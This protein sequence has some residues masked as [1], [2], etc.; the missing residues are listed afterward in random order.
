TGD[1]PLYEAVSA[2]RRYSGQEHWLPLFHDGLETLLD[3]TGGVPLS[4][5]HLVD[6]AVK[7]RFEQISEHYLARTE[8]L[9]SERF[10]A[11]PYKPVPPDT[12]FLNAASWSK[13]LSAHKVVR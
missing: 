10:G 6:D 2:G 4:F 7:N 11:P 1:D 12:M 3:Y 8:G 13:A 5:D 9:E